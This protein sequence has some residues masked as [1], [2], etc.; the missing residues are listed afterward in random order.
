MA[1]DRLTGYLGLG[2]LPTDTSAAASFRHQVKTGFGPCRN[3]LAVIDT[4]GGHR[5]RQIPHKR[6][7]AST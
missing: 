3:N 2:G 7:S 5:F 1:K 4:K 6:V